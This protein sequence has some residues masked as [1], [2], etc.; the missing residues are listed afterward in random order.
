MGPVSKILFLFHQKLRLFEYLLG[1]D[2]IK[3][4]LSIFA[5]LTL[6][7]KK[8]HQNYLEVLKNFENQLSFIAI[9]SIIFY[10]NQAR[11]LNFKEFTT[12]GA[13]GIF[14]PKS[15]R[16]PRWRAKRREQEYI[17]SV[18]GT[19][20]TSAVFSWTLEKIFSDTLGWNFLALFHTE[21]EI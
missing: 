11:S 7:V 20:L 10:Q 12:L 14:F 5:S 16:T 2:K 3:Q 17:F 9:E 1:S 19:S 8:P 6:A 18:L 21:L 15:K 13:R 4:L